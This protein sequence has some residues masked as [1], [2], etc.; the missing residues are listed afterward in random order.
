VSL[1]WRGRHGGGA[2]DHQRHSCNVVGNCSATPS[3]FRTRRA[4][5][6]DRLSRRPRMD[7][8][9]VADQ[10]P[11]IPRR[12]LRASSIAFC[13]GDERQ[14]KAG[15]RFVIVARESSKR[16]AGSMGSTASTIRRAASGSTL[17]RVGRSAR[18]R[19]RAAADAA[20]TRLA[21]LGVFLANARKASVLFFGAAIRRRH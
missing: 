4:Q 1:N 20:L 18:H 10:G 21:T 7:P 14:S 13:K 17:P 5:D 11:G 9:G 3:N 19:P 15:P 12:S 16:M 2:C 8:V 6:R